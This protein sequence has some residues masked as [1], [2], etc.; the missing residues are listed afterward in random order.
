MIEFKAKN[1]QSFKAYK[2]V[3]PNGQTACNNT[4]L[5]PGLNA[6]INGVGFHLF[7]SYNDAINGL[8]YIF[9]FETKKVGIILE[10]ECETKHLSGIESIVETKQYYPTQKV[11]RMHCG[12]IAR[13][14]VVSQ[15]NITPEVWNNNITD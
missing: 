12:K 13:Q 10:V 15:M 2:V 14:L 11:W 7:A 6:N 4:Q 5:K 3:W 9:T 8:A 1:P